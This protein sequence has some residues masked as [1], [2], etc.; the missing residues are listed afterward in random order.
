[1]I[2]LTEKQNNI[3]QFIAAHIKERSYPPT[4]REIAGH[5]A[6]STKGAFDHVSALKKKKR[7]KMSDRGSRTIEI[8]AD[9][10]EDNP[11]GFSEVPL[12][13]DVAAGPR[14]YSEENDNGVMRIHNSMLKENKRYFALS[15][16]GDSMIDI[17]V[18]DGDT[19]IIEKCESAKYGDVVVVDIDDGGRTLKR[20]KPQGCRIKLES[21][22]PKYPPTFCTDIRILGKL[23]GVYRSYA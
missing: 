13:G 1:M 5:F 11:E 15:V 22:N 20:Y 7:I 19:V 21:E 18:M 17:G 8:I 6:I 2:N 9:K 4:I 16:R 10:D 12:L 14:I 3:L 23:A